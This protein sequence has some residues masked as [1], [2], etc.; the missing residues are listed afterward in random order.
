MRER[1]RKRLRNTV[2]NRE[3]SGLSECGRNFPRRK[4]PRETRLVEFLN[5]PQAKKCS[6]T[7]VA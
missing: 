3:G 7:R 5:P 6:S 1:E 2:F 4:H